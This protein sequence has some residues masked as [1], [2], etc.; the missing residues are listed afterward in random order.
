MGHR[1]K[2]FVTVKFISLKLLMLKLVALIW[3]LTG[4]HDQM[5]TLID[6]WNITLTLKFRIRDFLKMTRPGFLQELVIKAY[7]PD[8]VW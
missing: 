3:V 8:C 5:I 4:H 2:E 7:V 6:L 1:H